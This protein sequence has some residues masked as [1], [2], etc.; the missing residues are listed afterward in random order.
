MPHGFCHDANLHTAYNSVGLQKFI[1]Y[2]LFKHYIT[3]IA[4]LNCKII[5][6]VKLEIQHSVKCTTNGY[7]V[8][9]Q[10]NTYYYKQATQRMSLA[11]IARPAKLIYVEVENDCFGQLS[12]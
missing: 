9:T 3:T 6:T 11:Q 4:S 1:T 12:I 2:L 5:Y 8:T 10:L 7:S